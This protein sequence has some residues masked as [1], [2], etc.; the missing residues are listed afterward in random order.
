MEHPAQMIKEA[1]PLDPIGHLLYKVTLQSLVDVETLSNAWKQTQG[2]SQN[3]ET[4]KHPK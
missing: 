3:E 2:G 1:V 4:K